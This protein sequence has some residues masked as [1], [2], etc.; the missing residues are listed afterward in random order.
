MYFVNISPKQLS[1]FQC[2]ILV[3]HSVLSGSWES[4]PPSPY[5]FWVPPVFHTG[6]LYVNNHIASPIQIIVYLLR[7]LNYTGVGTDVRRMVSRSFIP[8]PLYSVK[9][10]RNTICTICFSYSNCAP[11]WLHHVHEVNVHVGPTHIGTCG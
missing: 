11:V 5:I 9:M 1:Y 3:V 6:K 7:G 4:N 2:V 10:I 8:P